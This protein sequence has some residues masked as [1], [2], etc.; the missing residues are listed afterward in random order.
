M[1]GTSTREYE[2]NHFNIS[3]QLASHDDLMRLKVPYKNPIIRRIFS[4]WQSLLPYYK[5]RV[6]EERH[7]HY[8]ENMLKAGSNACIIGYWQSEK[9]F[10]DIRQSLLQDFSFREPLNGRN[11]EVAGRIAN[12]QSVSLHIRRTH[13]VPQPPSKEIHGTCPPEY[14]FSAIHFIR[15]KVSA[16]V[17]FIFSDDMQ[18]CRKNL[19]MPEETHF[20]DWNTDK[21]SFRDMQLMSLCRHNIIANSSFSWWAA[22][23]GTHDNKIVV[24]PNRWFLD[25]AI[26]IKD[27]LPGSWIKL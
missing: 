14:V 17:F 13:Y 25:T 24:A 9:Y 2:L 5:R 21:D 3:A 4:R 11:L 20:I 18:W 12:S 6:I 10:T 8:D 27:L 26:N 22:W 19:V 1:T 7:F 15:Q 23:L 16:P